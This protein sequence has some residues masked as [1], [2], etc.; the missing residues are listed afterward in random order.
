MSSRIDDGVATLTLSRPPLNILNMEMMQDLLE[1][2]AHATSGRGIKAVV[3]RS[4]LP[5]VFSAGADIRDHLPPQTEG[6]IKTFEK[7][8]SSLAFFPRP[9]VSA[10]RGKCLGGGME[11]ALACD[12]VVAEEGST[13]GQPE[14]NL[15]VYP[16]AAAAIYPRLVGLKA[17][18]D[19]VLTGRSI[20]ADEAYSL[21]FITSVAR[22]GELDS[23]CDEILEALRSKSSQVLGVAKRAMLDCLSLPLGEALTKSSTLYLEELMKMQDPQEGLASFMEKRK[24]HWQDG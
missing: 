6:F 9:T 10:V 16:P 20:S 8:V 2:L 3:L 4:G 1:E 15:G 5:G 12:F 18:S 14:V 21:G 11:L 7:L 23:K 24:P 13:F 19:I 17:A 22:P